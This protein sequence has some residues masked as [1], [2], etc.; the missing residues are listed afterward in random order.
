M[1][2]FAC[3]ALC[4]IAPLAACGGGGDPPG[5]DEHYDCSME[6]RQDEFVVGLEK[7]SP[8]GT[9]FI[10][11]SSVPAPPGRGDNHFV[12]HL[13]DSSAAPMAGAT[14]T[15]RP[16][17]PDHGHGTAVPVVITESTTVVG[18]YDVNPVNFHMPGLWQVLISAGSVTD[19]NTA[20]FAFCVP[21]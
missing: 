20:V 10:L 17:M 3:I 11:M 9:H 7:V 15:V 1:R 21:G 2:R 5:D 12:L 6:T 18:E 19:A 4:A 14:L 16:Y 8:S 13:T